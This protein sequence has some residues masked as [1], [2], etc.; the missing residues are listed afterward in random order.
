MNI[1]EANKIIKN[2]DILSSNMDDEVVM[3]SVENSE[4]YNLNPVGAKIWELL[5]NSPSFSGLID[6]LLEEFNVDKDL[7]IKDTSE[8]LEE[9]RSKGLIDIK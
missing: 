7:C 1:T 4:Y 8:F 5:D 2:K 9:L 6:K 3:M